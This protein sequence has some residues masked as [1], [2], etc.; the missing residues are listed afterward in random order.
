VVARPARLGTA[1]VG[2]TISPFDAY[3]NRL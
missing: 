1:M 2:Y 3:L